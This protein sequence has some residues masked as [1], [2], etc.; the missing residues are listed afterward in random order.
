MLKS[1]RYSVF[2]DIIW[3]LTMFSCRLIRI[4]YLSHLISLP[5][6]I[7]HKQEQIQV[8][9]EAGCLLTKFFQQQLWLETIDAHSSQCIFTI[10]CWICWRAIY[11]RLQHPL[12]P[13]TLQQLS[14]THMQLLHSPQLEISPSAERRDKINSAFLEPQAPYTESRCAH[15]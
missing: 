11:H 10:Q 6:S 14:C 8:I 7:S 15:I 12:N 9:I 3:S 5:R 13:N 2:N 1:P 4:S